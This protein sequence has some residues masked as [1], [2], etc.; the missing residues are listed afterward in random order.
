LLGIYG[1]DPTAQVEFFHKTATDRKLL[2]TKH[3]PAFLHVT[4]G[5]A[6]R[7][8]HFAAYDR[9]CIQRVDLPFSIASTTPLYD[10]DETPA[11]QRRAS[12]GSAYLFFFETCRVLLIANFHHSCL[13]YS[14]GTRS[15]QLYDKCVVAVSSCSSQ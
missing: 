5:E 8:R 13:L 10:K 3:L 1:D 9:A 12:T 14:H 4:V 11:Q 6:G 7:L 15:W 2:K